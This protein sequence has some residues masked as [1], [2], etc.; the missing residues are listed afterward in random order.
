MGPSFSHVK[1]RRRNWNGIIRQFVLMKKHLCMC[2][3]LSGPHFNQY[4]SH[5]PFSSDTGSVLHSIN[6]IIPPCMAE[7]FSD[8]IFATPF[9]SFFLVFP[10]GYVPI[11]LFEYRCTSISY[12]LRGIWV[13]LFKGV[14]LKSS[15]IVGDNVLKILFLL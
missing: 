13:N 15:D 4:P 5:F 14:C 12:V 1:S 2:S 11:F 10:S 3:L 8:C 9:F 6:V 7:H